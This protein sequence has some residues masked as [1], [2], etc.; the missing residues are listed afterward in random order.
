D[1]SPALEL[2]T[3]VGEIADDAMGE[4]VDYET[5]AAVARQ[6]EE[7][8]SRERENAALEPLIERLAGRDETARQELLHQAT[9]ASNLIVDL[10]ARELHRRPDTN[11]APFD[12][13]IDG[14]L[15]SQVA[16][17]HAG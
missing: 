3:R 10:V 15:A 16:A 11:L 5:L 2:L 4:R 13:V 9:E 1:A 7:H 17:P 14:C 6:I 12:V 8:L